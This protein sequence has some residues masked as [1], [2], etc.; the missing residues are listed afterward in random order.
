[1]PRFPWGRTKRGSD[2]HSALAAA[3]RLAAEGRALNA[4]ELLTEANR[5][6]RDRKIERR[7]V[8]LRSEAFLSLS[9]SA[10]R[11]VWP[12]SVPDLF[13]GVEDGYSPRDQIPIL[14]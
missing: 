3:D 2:P 8:E 5:A 11:P 4:I 13:P 9:W 1:M 6:A 14:L 10:E 7:L 12:E